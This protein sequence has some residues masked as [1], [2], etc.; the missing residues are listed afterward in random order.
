MLLKTRF[1][2]RCFGVLISASVSSS[3]LML[4]LRDYF[5]IIIA[6]FLLHWAMK[7][8]FKIVEQ[9]FWKALKFVGNFVWLSRLIFVT[10]F[11]P[12]FLVLCVYDCDSIF[13]SDV[14]YI[15]MSW[16]YLVF[17]FRLFSWPVFVQFNFR[18]SEELVRTRHI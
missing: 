3:I 9:S 17:C 16:K 10:C 7:L 11:Q 2:S 6:Y 18:I 8:V 14:I 12:E 5:W 13:L 4:M 15:N 1:L